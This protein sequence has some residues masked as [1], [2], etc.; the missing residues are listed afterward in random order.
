MKA[1]FIVVSVVLVGIC[2]AQQRGKDSTCL[3]DNGQF[4]HEDYCDYFYDCIDGVATLQLCPN[5]LAF[6]GKG[7]GLIQSCDY[8]KRVGCPDG[9]RVMGQSPISTE[10]CNWL[11]GRFPHKTS[12][13]SY[14]ECWNGTATLSRCGISLLYSTESEACEWP[15]NVPGCQQHPT[16]KNIANGAVPI[17]NSC[18][19]FWQCIGGYP[20]I[21]ECPAGLAFDPQ[22]L[23]CRL[24]VDVPGCEPPPTT[25]APEDEELPVSGNRR[26]TGAGLQRQNYQSLDTGSSNQLPLNNNRVNNRPQFRTVPGK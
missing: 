21:Q 12:C 10:N 22:F 3:Y 2:S 15:E 6:Q 17:E 7:R 25:A 8:P 9:K 26:R 4:P 19:N 14:W 11:W 5:G 23:G 20:F 13:T 24:A 16:C 1:L 18:K